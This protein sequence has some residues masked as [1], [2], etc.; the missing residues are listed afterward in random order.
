MA[1]ASRATAAHW[2][3]RDSY[4]AALYCAICPLYRLC[5]GIHC[6]ASPL[7]CDEFCCGRK[8][9]CTTVCRYN[10]DF[11]I[12]LA[13]VGGFDLDRLP[14]ISGPRVQLANRIAPLVYHGSKRALRV[15]PGLVALRL[16][17]LIDFA[18]ASSRYRSRE[19]LCEAFRI[20]EAAKII[21]TGVDHDPV[22][23]KVWKLGPKRPSVLRSLAGLGIECATTPNFSMVLDV[24]RSDNL[25]SMQRIGI[26]YNEMCEAG[27]P[28]AL[29]INGRTD[30]DF[31]RWGSFLADRPYV[32]AVS[33]EFIT[34]AGLAGRIDKHLMW[35][36]DLRTR[37]GRPL[38]CIL[39]G[40][41]TCLDYL[42]S[43]YAPVYIETTSF[44]KTVKRQISRRYGNWNLRWNTAKSSST[45]D[46]SSA[47]GLNISEVHRSLSTRY[48]RL[49]P[50]S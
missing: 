50:T 27:L 7:G 4:P 40:N 5:G 15:S 14:H 6:K 3:D 20:D 25:H 41:P 16:A 1:S 9:G 8:E 26:L 34:G 42:D 49:G 35:L 31:D 44:V 47:L 22:I 19:Q 13:E 23:E 33:Y 46:L 2:D 29:H 30:R 12:Q 36:N 32:D 11:L 38:T 17:D 45:T 39:R 28:T 43:G 10:P 48:T 18:G 24:P 37:I 21:L